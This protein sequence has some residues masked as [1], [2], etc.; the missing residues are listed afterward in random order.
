MKKLFSLLFASF[1]AM[2]VSAASYGIMING[3]DFHEATANPTPG[4]PSFQEYMALN[5]QVPANATLQL[6]DNDN[7]AGWAVDLDAASVAG[8]VKDGDHYTCA[9]G[10]CFSFY[11]K[12]KYQ[13][14]QLYIGNGECTPGGGGGQGQGGGQGGG[15]T[16]DGNPRYYWKGWVDGSDVEPDASTMFED[17]VSAITV[18]ENAYLF[19]LYQVDGAQGVQYMTEACVDG[20][21]HTTLYVDGNGGYEKLHLGAGEYDLYLYDNGNGTLELSTEVLPGKTLVG[22]GQ[23]QGFEQVRAQKTVN[24][25][26]VNGQMVITVDGVRYNA[27]GVRL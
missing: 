14:D 17:G 24:K 27:N 11:I 19:V 20:V 26:L 13:H 4:D 10:G 2:A 7:K 6:Y 18:T 8:I 9:A 21:S 15:Q 22:G 1:V 3:T 5:V 23:A 25:S 16:G 12:L